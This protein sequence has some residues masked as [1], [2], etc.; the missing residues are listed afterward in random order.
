MPCNT[1]WLV[2]WAMRHH[3]GLLTAKRGRHV[4]LRRAA[5]RAHHGGPACRGE[6]PQ[7]WGRAIL[8][9]NRPYVVLADY[10]HVVILQTRCMF[11]TCMCV[12]SSNPKEIE[13]PNASKKT[14]SANIEGSNDYLVTSANIAR[15]SKTNL[16]IDVV[17]HHS[18]RKVSLSDLWCN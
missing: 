9:T 7:A 16:S 12:E 3:T 2:L 5:L 14:A 11:R 1:L 6:L 10:I 15:M 13:R 4:K 8:Y 17:K 18:S